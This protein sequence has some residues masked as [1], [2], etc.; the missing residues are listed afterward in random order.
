MEG[1]QLT[2]KIHKVLMVLIYLSLVVFLFLL[3]FFLFGFD[4][5]ECV[6]CWAKGCSLVGMR[7]AFH[8][9]LIGF[10][11]QMDPTLHLCSTLFSSLEGGGHSSSLGGLACKSELT[12]VGWKQVI[13]CVPSAKPCLP[14]FCLTILA[15]LCTEQLSCTTWLNNMLF[16]FCLFYITPPLSI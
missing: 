12:G 2:G 9:V 1:R 11:G 7:Y 3:L 8:R 6:C 13:C 5:S 4:F 14:S 15:L 10:G 16:F